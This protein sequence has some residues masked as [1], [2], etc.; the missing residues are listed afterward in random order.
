[1]CA[2]L[3]CDVHSMNLSAHFFVFFVLS[4]KLKK[5]LVHYV[6]HGI[7]TNVFLCAMHIVHAAAGGFSVVI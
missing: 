2:L 6:V 4:T 3:V 5:C 1:M 7:G